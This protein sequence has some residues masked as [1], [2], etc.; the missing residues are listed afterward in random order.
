MNPNNSTDEDICSRVAQPFPEKGGQSALLISSRRPFVNAK[1]SGCSE[2][3]SLFAEIRHYPIAS[4][5][6][7][8]QVEP[9]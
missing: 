9:G 4:W 8:F 1:T 7:D 6:N 2:T 3:E 5:R